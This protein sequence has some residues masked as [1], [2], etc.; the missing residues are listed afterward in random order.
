MRTILWVT[1]TITCITGIALGDDLEA[2]RDRDAAELAEKVKELNERC[3]TSVAVTYDRKAEPDSSCEGAMHCSGYYACQQV[4]Q[5]IGVACE[6]KEI[7]V[8]VAE[9]LQSI[10]CRYSQG[11]SKRTEASNNVVELALKDGVLSVQFDSGTNGTYHETAFAFARKLT[12]AVYTESPRCKKLR[13]PV[14]KL[15]P[16]DAED[17]AKKLTKP[18][19]MADADWKLCH[20]IQLQV[21]GSAASDWRYRHESHSSSSG[22]TSKVMHCKTDCASQCH[23]HSPGD[24]CQVAI[25]KC[26]RACE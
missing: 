19:G 26:Q 10:D 15:D 5:G 9:K 20:K 13:E 7:K 24:A 4:A 3:G 16:E 11:S 12:S 8:V 14:S 25:Q 2:K 21:L 1:V 23:A 18:K 6:H 17:A 22:N